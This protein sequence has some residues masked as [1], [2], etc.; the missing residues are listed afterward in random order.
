MTSSAE[1]MAQ[2]IVLMN[3]LEKPKSTQGLFVLPCG[4]I[5]DDGALHN[6]VELKELTGNEEDMLA[7]RTIPAHKKMGF[8]IGRCVRRLGTITDQGR[9]AAIAGDLT[10]G[11][12]T[13]LIFALRRITL[14]DM[15]PFKVG[16]PVCSKISTYQID[17]ADLETKFMPTPE[18]RIYDDKLPSGKT[19]RFR[20]LVGRDEEQLG[21]AKNVDDKA[22]LALLL[23]L[24]LIDGKP[25]TMADVKNLSMRDRDA[26]RV[27]V[28]DVDGG[29][30]TGLELSCPS[31]GAEFE[32][33][34]D[35][36][37]AGFFF[38]SMT[39]KRSKTRSST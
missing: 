11:D 29:V 30:E 25:P 26:L 17:M 1:D 38:P 18:K 3:E 20:I 10:I 9:L 35:A 34:V 33:D 14:G 15:Y 16:C 22:S 28:D 31:C 39:Q 32:D 5:D 27:L 24:E 6:E 21:K 7:S 4:Y 36:G 2:Q 8:L 37:Q 19:V 23:R 13:F 12:R